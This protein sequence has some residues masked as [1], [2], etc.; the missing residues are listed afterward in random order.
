MSSEEE[1]LGIYARCSDREVEE[2]TERETRRNKKEPFCGNDLGS[3][4][5]ELATL[6]L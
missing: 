5:S 4:D 3:N 2:R 1:E 6:I